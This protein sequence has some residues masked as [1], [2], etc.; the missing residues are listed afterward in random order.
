M[1][2]AKRRGSF[3]DRKNNPKRPMKSAELSAIIKSVKEFARK[4]PEMSNESL[5]RLYYE[6]VEEAIN[7]KKE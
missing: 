3:E 5:D 2:E 7:A 6:K 1:G 4:H